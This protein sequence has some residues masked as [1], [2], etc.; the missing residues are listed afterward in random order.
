VLSIFGLDD[1]RRYDDV[2]EEQ[3]FSTDYNNT[4]LDAEGFAID[5][6]T[7]LPVH[8]SPIGPLCKTNGTPYENQPTLFLKPEPLPFK[9]VKKIYLQRKESN[10][11]FLKEMDK[12]YNTFKR[13]KNRGRQPRLYNSDGLTSSWG[14]PV[15]T[16]TSFKSSSNIRGLSDN[17]TYKDFDFNGYQPSSGDEYENDRDWRRKSNRTS[18]SRHISSSRLQRNTRSVVIDSSDEDSEEYDNDDYGDGI[19][20]I[21]SR[22]QRAILRAQRTKEWDSDESD[23]DVTNEV[24]GDF[25]SLKTRG[26]PKRSREISSPSREVRNSYKTKSK[27][28]D[29]IDSSI[30]V[31]G[32][33]VEIY[34]E[35]KEKRVW[36][37]KNHVN[38]PFGVD[39]DREWLQEDT[40]TEKYY[41]P[42]LGDRIVYFPQ[43]HIQLLERFPESRQPP[44]NSFAQNWPVVECIIQEM[45]FHFPTQAAHRKCTSIVASITL[46]IVRTPSK[47]HTS[48]SGLNLVDLM[49]PRNTRNSTQLNHT[50]E[51]DFRNYEIPDFIVPYHLFE[52]SIKT[53]W[54]NGIPIS[55]YYKEINSFGVDEYIDYNGEVIA[56]TDC[57]RNDWPYSPWDNLEIK[58]H[59]EN[60]NHDPFV[61]VITERI[62]PWEVFP[63]DNEV[64]ANLREN[65]KAPSLSVEFSTTL[66]KLLGQ[67]MDK[68]QSL[69]HPFE[70]EVDSAEFPD[71]YYQVP[72]PI[73][74]D[75]IRRRLLNG[76]Y[77]Q[78]ESLYFDIDKIES[79]CKIYNREGAEISLTAEDFVEKVKKIIRKQLG[80]NDV[81]DSEKD[82]KDDE[83]NDDDGSGDDDNDDGNEKKKLKLEE[84]K[85]NEN[86][87]LGI[88][89]S[90]RSVH[91]T[92]NQSISPPLTLTLPSRRRQNPS[93]DNSKSS[94]LS[95][96][97]NRSNPS[98]VVESSYSGR[99]TRLNPPVVVEDLGRRSSRSAKPISYLEHEESSIMEV[100][101]GDE[102]GDV[103]EEIVVKNEG[104]RIRQ[105]SVKASEN[106]TYSS[107][108]SLRVTRGS[109][110]NQPVIK[111]ARSNNKKYDY[112]SEEEGYDD[113]SEVDDYNTKRTNT[114]RSSSRHKN[115]EVK[116]VTMKPIVHP[117]RAS[118][119]QRVQQEE[120]TPISRKRLDP[121]TKK[122]LLEM[123]TLIETEDEQGIFINP[124]TDDI[125]PGY[126]DIIDQ[127]MDL[128][129][130]RHKMQSRMYDSIKEMADDLHLML[131]NCLLFNEDSSYLAVEAS[132]LKEFVQVLFSSL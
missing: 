1:P 18:S 71:Y 118:K 41:Q 80:D 111:T 63:T 46:E 86:D 127:P 60:T 52:R 62:N 119:Q 32:S 109:T 103:E 94:S 126:S 129:T 82:S 11:E 19:V 51:I 12:M 83:G 131:D 65:Y 45:S 4:V 113:D 8:E 73:Y 21:S 102:E 95:S 7:Q 48:H 55:V 2:F 17:I 92:M 108:F 100:N 89:R 104:R 43:G 49:V 10:E 107:S 76:Y 132:R 16:S 121:D 37:K 59:D 69:Y 58:F 64:A 38:L 97:S 66:E 54:F 117:P 42:Q 13:N 122:K 78:I 112:S 30:Y 85:H 81:S 98:V 128:T 105:L 5:I 130:I 27:S 88:R 79:N 14:N 110:R 123:L 57:N 6:S 33:D 114:R 74:V 25:V 84:V 31:E 87:E 9:D 15:K 91:L 22:N 67:L 96:R 72:V 70:Y 40:Q 101:D 26:R 53:P 93:I 50:F 36:A 124:V 120:E 20:G 24:S 34:E 106:D 35:K 115:I 44:W 47:L 61:P 77:R 23:D 29:K 99:I 68:N 39:V 56:L 90:A 116:Q 3:F 28:K 75:L 125:A